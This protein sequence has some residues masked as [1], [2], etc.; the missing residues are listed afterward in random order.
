MI[1][2]MK[3]LWP[4]ALSDI[5]LSNNDTMLI[6]PCPLLDWDSINCFNKDFSMNHSIKKRSI[7]YA[8]LSDFLSRKYHIHVG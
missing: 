3:N 5:R 8:F 6:L 4:K 2:I 1:I 7:S